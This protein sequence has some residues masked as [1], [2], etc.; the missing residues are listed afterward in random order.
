MTERL[1]RR[2][3]PLNARGQVEQKR[4]LKSSI[5]AHVQHRS[6]AGLRIKTK[7][8]KLIPQTE[9]WPWLTHISSYIFSTSCVSLKK[10]KQMVEVSDPVF[11]IQA[12]ITVCSSAMFII[13]LT[14]FSM[15]CTEDLLIFVPMNL[16]CQSIHLVVFHQA[17]EPNLAES[18]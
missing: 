15:I 1:H 6:L 4:G 9:R 11:R 7:W 17:S 16:L 18:V 12:R 8:A 14:T 3:Q 13:N 5:S 2:E 10:K